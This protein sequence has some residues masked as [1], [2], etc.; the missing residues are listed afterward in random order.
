[1]TA[2]SRSCFAVFHGIMMQMGMLH[3]APFESFSFHET[4]QNMLDYFLQDQ[5][6]AKRK[7][8]IFDFNY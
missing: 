6:K 4:D 1:M 5:N 3:F 7:S 8:R 2:Y